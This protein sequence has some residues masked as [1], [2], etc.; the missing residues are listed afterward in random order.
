MQCDFA[1]LLKFKKRSTS[2]GKTNSFIF[3]NCCEWSFKKCFSSTFLIS[4]LRTAS[5]PLRI[6]HKTE[7]KRIAF[8]DK[9]TFG[10]AKILLFF[11]WLRQKEDLYSKNYFRNS[12]KNLFLLNCVYICCP[13]YISKNLNEKTLIVRLSQMCRSFAF[14]KKFLPVI[15]FFN[16]SQH[17]QLWNVFAALL[18]TVMTSGLEL[19]FQIIR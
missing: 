13:W 9:G 11:M 4:R 17:R 8:C 16:P 18:S 12:W 6:T 2:F 1:N 19:W 10:L 3:S 14:R 5:R 15:C 7:G